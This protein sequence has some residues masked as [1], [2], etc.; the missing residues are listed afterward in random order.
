MV[1]SGCVVQSVIELSHCYAVYKGVICVADSP[2]SWWSRR[3][4]QSCLCGGRTWKEY[5]YYYNYIILALYVYMLL[6]D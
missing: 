4:D 2:T 6:G 5:V 3:W 1:Q